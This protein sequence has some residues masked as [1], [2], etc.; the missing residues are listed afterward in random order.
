MDYSVGMLFKWKKER[1]RERET[2]GEGEWEGLR[3]RERI[4][5]RNLR[6][7]SIESP[8]FEEVGFILLA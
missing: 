4:D 6:R 5:R 7:V 2:N 3:E 8:I 1:E